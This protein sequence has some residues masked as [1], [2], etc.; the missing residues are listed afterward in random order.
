MAT[1][2]SLSTCVT[3]MC[4]G[5]IVEV[6]AMACAHVCGQIGGTRFHASDIIDPAV[7]I[8]IKRH[9][10]CHVNKGKWLNLISS[11]IA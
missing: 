3:S 1:R 11:S 4:P 2:T 6:D 8:V 5:D 9:V 7:G 10:G